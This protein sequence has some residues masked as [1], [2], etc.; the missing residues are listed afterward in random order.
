MQPYVGCP[1]AL[2]TSSGS[3]VDQLVQRGW[4]LYPVNPKAAERYR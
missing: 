2:E 3:A 4:P 1:L